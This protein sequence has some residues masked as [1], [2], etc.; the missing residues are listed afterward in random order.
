MKKIIEYYSILSDHVFATP[1]YTHSELVEVD[2]E[3]ELQKYI[4]SKKDRYGGSFKKK[5]KDF[6]DYQYTSHSGGV[7]VR[8]YNPPKFKKISS[9]KLKKK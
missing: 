5:D 7:K 8:D 3:E 2:T 6:M 4:E 1:E 9:K